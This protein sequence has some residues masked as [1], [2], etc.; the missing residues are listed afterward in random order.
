[1]I[2]IRKQKLFLAL[3]LAFLIA[4]VTVIPASAAPDGY[5]DTTPKYVEIDK[6]FNFKKN[7]HVTVPL[8]I[9]NYVTY[10]PKGRFV[11][12]LDLKNP[13]TTVTHQDGSGYHYA[14]YTGYVY[15][16]PNGY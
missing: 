1:M 6:T 8:K 5:Y 16:N 11:G 12:T 15:F 9:Y 7:E 10:F 14:K 4:L 3:T 2:T 13:V